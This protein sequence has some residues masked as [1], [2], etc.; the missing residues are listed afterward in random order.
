MLNSFWKRWQ[1]D[2][3]LGLSALKK[4][5]KQGEEMIKV[6][7]VVLII[8][9]DMPKNS[10]KIARVLEVNTNEKGQVR[11]AKLK[12]PNGKPIHRSIRQLALLESDMTVKGPR[13]GELS[14]QAEEAADDMEVEPTQEEEAPARLKRK[15]KLPWKLKV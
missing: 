13:E 12:V 15:R 8:E 2:Y 5:R 10:W 7:D 1:K 6:G 4:W 11:S 9:Q 14:N 3:L